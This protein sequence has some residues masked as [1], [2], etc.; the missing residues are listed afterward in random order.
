MRIWLSTWYA[1][2]QN[3]AT[4]HDTAF[5]YFFY[6]GIKARDFRKVILLPEL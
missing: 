5:I 3:A 4:G 2:I 1:T 6:S